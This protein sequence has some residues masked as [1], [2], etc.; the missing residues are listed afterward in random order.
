MEKK[1]SKQFCKHRNVQRK[2]K[3]QEKHQTYRKQIVNL[4]QICKEAYFK[5]FL[6]RNRTN[7]EK[8]WDGIKTLININ[9]RQISL[10][11]INL[12]INGETVTDEI[13]LANNFNILFTS[14]AGKLLKNV[15]PT[16][17]AMHSYLKKF[18]FSY[19]NNNLRN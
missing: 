19:S 4:G 6:K 17:K 14:V 13:R 8:V 11:Q 16:A 1:L 7:C 18:F 12:N 5:N 3:P 10:K 15:P 2:T 9:K